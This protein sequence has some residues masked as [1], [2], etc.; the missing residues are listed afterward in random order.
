VPVVLWRTFRSV[1]WNLYNFCVK[2][3]ALHL[4]EKYNVLPQGL[5]TYNNMCISAIQFVYKENE[6][7]NVK[8]KLTT[9]KYKFKKWKINY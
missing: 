3:M 5:D 4:K 1:S 2:E 6:D 8:T 9:P 7:N